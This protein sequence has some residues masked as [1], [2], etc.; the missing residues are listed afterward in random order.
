MAK[1]ITQPISGSPSP[2][3][4]ALT[5]EQLVVISKAIT[6]VSKVLANTQQLEHYT[7]EQLESTVSRMTKALGKSLMKGTATV[8]PATLAFIRDS[9][10][11]LI[12]MAANSAVAISDQIN[13]ALQKPYQEPASSS[14]VRRPVTVMSEV[15]RENVARTSKRAFANAACEQAREDAIKGITG[16]QL[17]ENAFN[18]GLQAAYTSSDGLALILG[19]QNSMF[20]NIVN[21]ELPSIS[22]Y[23]I[24]AA[25]LAQI[26]YMTK[27]TTHE[28]EIDITYG[29]VRVRKQQAKSSSSGS[30]AVYAK[31]EPELV[32]IIK[33]RLH[34]YIPPTTKHPPP[35]VS[36]YVPPTSKHPIPPKVPQLIPPKF[37]AKVHSA[38]FSKS[39]SMGW[40]PAMGTSKWVRNPAQPPPPKAE[41]GSGRKSRAKKL[42]AG[43]GEC[44]TGDE[45]SV[46]PKSTTK[47][48]KVVK[49]IP[50]PHP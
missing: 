15:T 42:V 33:P 43:T 11:D 32:P 3:K 37:P 31:T 41:A 22:Q 36:V 39:A 35:K 18:A 46:K 23:A 38:P 12:G 26:Q 30:Q 45:I 4:S 13:K 16:A 17:A 49:V 8:V 7:P 48:K 5:E 44:N 2:P 50:S 34:K 29:P 6:P 27:A 47:K 19:Y 40:I 20:R 10:L 14:I 21:E 1:I 24:D 25:T 9:G 28:P